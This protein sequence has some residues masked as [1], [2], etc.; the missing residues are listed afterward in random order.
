MDQVIAG[1][2]PDELFRTLMASVKN[3]SKTS[4]AHHEAQ[5]AKFEFERFLDE[6]AYWAAIESFKNR[7]AYRPCAAL[8]DAKDIHDFVISNDWVSFKY[9]AGD[10]SYWPQTK[11]LKEAEQR[12]REAIQRF[13]VRA[14][15]TTEYESFAASE[16][17]LTRIRED[18]SLMTEAITDTVDSVNRYAELARM[19]TERLKN[20]G[21]LEA[22]AAAIEHARN[23]IAEEKAAG[24]FNAKT[25]SGVWFH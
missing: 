25:W 4:Q 17:S 3:G 9:G 10:F 5:L 18:V 8:H 6:A 12:A 14:V 24:R 20:L 19:E 22:M 2:D 16:E 7:A 13:R 21:M 1:F 11:S 15:A 23:A